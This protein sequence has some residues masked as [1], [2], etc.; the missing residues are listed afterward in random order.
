MN[1]K[2]KYWFLLILLLITVSCGFQPIYKTGDGKERLLEFDLNFLNG[3]SYETQN[4]IKS[5]FQGSQSTAL[6]SINLSVLENQSALVTNSNG[7]VSKYRVEVI[8]DFKVNESSSGKIIYTDI[9]RGFSEY[10]VQTSEIETNDKYKQAIGI[11][12]QE[13]V[14]MMSI[15]IQSNI[16]QSQ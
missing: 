12:A 15:K 16:L 6:Y 14:Q 13:A 11:A 5:T 8:V 1:L 9:S 2:G 3:A 7:T 4:I 10:L